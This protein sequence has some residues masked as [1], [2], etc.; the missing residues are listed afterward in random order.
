[1]S[2]PMKRPNALQPDRM[3]ARERRRELCSLLAIGLVRLH[4]RDVAKPSENIGES[5]LHF[6]A[7]QSVHAT[8]TRKEDA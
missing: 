1:M 2:N 7:G 6:P 5:S 8:P 3:T 4:Q